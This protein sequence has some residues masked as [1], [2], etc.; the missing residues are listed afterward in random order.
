MVQ[1]ENESASVSPI[2]IRVA[3]PA[4]AEL[5]ARI[6]SEYF[7]QAF[8]AMNTAEDLADY[9]A[10]AFSA[11]IQAREIDAVGSMF[12]IA[13]SGGSAVGYAR[14][15]TSKAPECVSASRPIELV[16][17]YVDAAFHGGGAAHQLMKEVVEHAASDNHD[18][19]WLGVWEHNPRAIAFYRKWGFEIV[20]T[21][22]FVV[23]KDAQTDYVMARR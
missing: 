16:R 12:F 6:G 15:E 2:I 8:G 17:L 3:R 21:K 9:L 19:V 10:S 5:L 18:A 4:D 20:G 13:D 7:I 23:G 22:A 11:E 14:T 1:F